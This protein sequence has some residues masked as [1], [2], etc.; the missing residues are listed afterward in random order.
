[1]YFLAA[2]ARQTTTAAAPSLGLQYMY[3]RSGALTI[4]E[5]RIAST[6]IGLRRQALGLRA[7]LSK[8]LAATRASVCS[9]MPWSCM[10]RM[11]LVPK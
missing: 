10:Y 5:A 2:S 11:I 6:L 3:C 7:P 8:F 9:V 1:M 4:G